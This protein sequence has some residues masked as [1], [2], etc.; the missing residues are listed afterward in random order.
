MALAHEI[1]VNQDFQVKPTELPEGRYDF[2]WLLLF[3]V[4]YVY[5]FV[6]TFF[7]LLVYSLERTVKE[8]M[9][10]AFWDCLESQLKEDPPTYGHAIKLVAEIK[11]VRLGYFV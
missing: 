4:R 7:F 2:V 8:I 6:H 9:H 3:N 11:E 5:N 1:M 10:K